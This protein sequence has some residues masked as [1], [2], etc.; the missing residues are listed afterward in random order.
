VGRP[1]IASQRH[2]TGDFFVA[3]ELWRQV[4]L[5]QLERT[6]DLKI[7]IV[8][9][10]VLQ[11]AAIKIAATYTVDQD[12]FTEAALEQCQPYWDWAKNSVPPAEVISLDQLTIIMK[13]DE[14]EP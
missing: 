7:V 8:M 4:L 5:Y 3:L 11:A 1:E 9:Q 6:V 10:Q 12:R 2:Q 13:I 14:P